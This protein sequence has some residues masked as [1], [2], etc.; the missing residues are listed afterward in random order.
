M[1]Y[2]V[3]QP[4]PGTGRTGRPGGSSSGSP[5]IRPGSNRTVSDFPS[6]TQFTYQTGNPYAGHS[7]YSS[8]IGAG[9]VSARPHA[10]HSSSVTYLTGAG[11]RGR[12]GVRGM[13]GGRGRGR[14]RGG[15]KQPQP[16]MIKPKG[17]PPLT[18]DQRARVENNNMKQLV[19]PKPPCQ[20]LQ[21][22]RG[23]GVTFEY[24]ENPPLPPGQMMQDCPPMHTLITEIEG[25]RSSGTGPTH[26]IAKNIC[27][28]HAIMGVVTKRYEEM[29]Q[30]GRSREDLLLE[31]ETPFELA[32]I[33]MFKLLNEW[34]AG[35]WT[36]PASM[37]RVLYG[38]VCPPVK[39][40]LAWI[41]GSNLGFT[42]A[43]PGG[44]GAGRKRPLPLPAEGSLE[45]KESCINIMQDANSI[46]QSFPIFD[47]SRY[48]E[49]PV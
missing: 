38:P 43:L 29:R 21:E 45:N 42:T 27:S 26:E 47:P 35:G 4:Q 40:R 10:T 31:D 12:G 41:R 13:R 11:A 49:I 3:Q 32:S 18:S 23:G 1:S 14:G 48:F 6:A 5:Y 22:M 19:A 33:A 25:D 39:Q 16:K 15:P 46:F 7:N 37:E 34:E 9:A 30:T 20:I 2:N 17:P 36:V 44:P 8:T 24:T 28:E